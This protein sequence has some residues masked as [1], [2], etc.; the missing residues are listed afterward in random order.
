MTVSF[1]KY[2]EGCNYLFLILGSN[3]QN[4]TNIQKETKYL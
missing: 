2:R 4:D 3:I 1:S